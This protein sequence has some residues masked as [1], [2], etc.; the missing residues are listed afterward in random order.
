MGILWIMDPLILWPMKT[1]RAYKLILRKEGWAGLSKKAGRPVAIGLFMFFLLK[2]IAWLV[3]A[4]GGF[5][6]IF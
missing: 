2:G 5:E 6:L 1:I 4:Y 3:L